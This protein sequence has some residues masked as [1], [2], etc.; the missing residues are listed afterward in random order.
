MVVR[1][2]LDGAEDGVA[3]FFP[4]TTDVFAAIEG[5][6]GE[7]AVVGEEGHLVVDFL[8]VELADD[9]EDADIVIVLLDHFGVDD[10]HAGSENSLHCVEVF[11]DIIVFERVGWLGESDVDGT[12]FV[13]INL[14]R[15]V[16]S[17]AIDVGDFGGGKFF[18]IA[19]DEHFIIIAIERNIASFNFVAIT[20]FDHDGIIVVDAGDDASDD[21][22]NDGDDGDE[23]DG[24][25]NALAGAGFLD[26]WGGCSCC[27]SS[28]GDGFDGLGLWRG[29][30][31]WL[32]GWF[33]GRFS[34]CLSGSRACCCH[35][36]IS[37]LQYNTYAY[38]TTELGNV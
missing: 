18:E 14:G 27:A 22:S 3:D 30:G 17:I 38:Y 7:L 16:G 31:C 33:L 26:G 34:F 28:F 5:N 21:A 29:F 13:G 23:D 25:E 8:V 4:F 1:L 11:F 35:D 37:S 24:D 15:S 19:R 2:E 9:A 12:V 36:N 20:V 6:D 32:R 10:F